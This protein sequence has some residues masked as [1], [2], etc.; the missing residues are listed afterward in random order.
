[1]IKTIKENVI[2]ENNFLKINNNDVVFEKTGRKDLY[3]KISHPY[4]YG[5]FI[6]ATNE[7]NEILL[8]KEYRYCLDSFDINVP[9][10][11]GDADSNP[12]DKAKEELME[13]A[14]FEGAGWNKV[15]VVRNEIYK[16]IGE[17]LFSTKVNTKNKM[18]TSHEDGE[19][20]IEEKFYSKEEV[21]K[22]INSGKITDSL[23]I[24]AIQY[25]VMIS[26]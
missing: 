2:F 21:M 17:I 6:L 24:I 25:W 5:V 4:P 19:N 11:M 18:K 15:M 16:E 23:T 9:R 26:Q 7:K 12:L 10:G 22:M 20:I 1:M 8:L 14:G 13:E 3:L